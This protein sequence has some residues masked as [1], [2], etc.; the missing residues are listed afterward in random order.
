METDALPLSVPTAVGPAV[1]LTI[2]SAFPGATCKINSK[3]L[4]FLLNSREKLDK[5]EQIQNH[6]L[7]DRVRRNP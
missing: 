1:E 2:A 3:L 5:G 7:R 4:M 6:Y